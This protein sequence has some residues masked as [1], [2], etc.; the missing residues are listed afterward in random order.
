MTGI[1][2]MLHNGRL[3]FSV[4]EL[5]GGVMLFEAK[6]ALPGS[7]AYV[8]GLVFAWLVVGTGARRKVDDAGFITGFELIFRLH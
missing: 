7:F 1:G 4:V 6:I 8:S 3:V 2:G 5:C